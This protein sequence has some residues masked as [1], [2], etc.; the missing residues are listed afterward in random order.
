MGLKLLTFLIIVDTSTGFESDR[1][2]LNFS[3]LLGCFQE[4]SLTYLYFTGYEHTDKGQ[5]L[6]LFELR[7]GFENDVLL[8]FRVISDLNVNTKF[9]PISANA[10]KFSA[11]SVIIFPQEQAQL[12]LDLILNTRST[13]SQLRHEFTIFLKSKTQIPTG[14]FFIPLITARAP[15]IYLEVE[16]FSKVFFICLPCCQSAVSLDKISSVVPIEAFKLRNFEVLDIRKKWTK[17]IRNM[18]KTKISS[19]QVP[20]VTAEIPGYFNSGQTTPCSTYPQRTMFMDRHGCAIVLISEM[21][22]FTLIL[23]N[24]WRHRPNLPEVHAEIFYYLFADQNNINF[25]KQ[26]GAMGSSY[27]VEVEYYAFAVFIDNEELILQDSKLK[28]ILAPFPW[29]LW[30][31]IVVFGFLTSLFL[32]CKCIVIGTEQVSWSIMHSWFILASLVVDQP[33]PQIIWRD[34]L[35]KLKLW[36]AWWFFCL[37]ISYTYRGLI[38]SSLA[39]ETTPVT[40]ETL[41]E[42]AESNIMLATSQ[43]FTRGS[44]AARRPTFT[45]NLLP[46]IMLSELTSERSKNM[47]SHLSKSVNFFSD[48]LNLASVEISLNHTTQVDSKVT[49]IPGTFA[50]IDPIWL[51]GEGKVFFEEIGKFWVSKLKMMDST[52]S[53]YLYWSSN[54]NYF[55]PTF[56]LALAQ[57]YESGLYDRWF[58]ISNDNIHKV[59]VQGIRQLETNQL[60]PT[61]DKVARGEHEISRAVYFEVLVHFCI[62]IGTTLLVFAIELLYKVTILKGFDIKI[63]HNLKTFML[64]FAFVIINLAKTRDVNELKM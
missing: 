22:N 11:C 13:Y 1:K 49:K 34:N 29:W 10:F 57:I 6:D 27:G 44:D 20:R 56:Q 23:G 28:G 36:G 48:E 9:N 61:E 33:A 30:L 18:H 60:I 26:A 15:T 58:K 45:E 37:V 3:S 4:C 16:K 62:F 21:H 52:F 46:K 14:N 8:Q 50:I 31:G 32:S 2:T 47:C 42:L 5:P 7:T 55:Y 59:V 54:Y 17:L 40:P 51:I 19:P 38:F 43:F 24:S 12:S 63:I 35:M 64:K 39:T 41:M 25:W 53:S